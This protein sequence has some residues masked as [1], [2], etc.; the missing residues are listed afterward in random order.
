MVPPNF[1]IRTNPDHLTIPIMTAMVVRSAGA[2]LNGHQVPDL[3]DFDPFGGD[4]VGFA[5]GV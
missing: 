5:F 4:R 2:A 3:G 1:R